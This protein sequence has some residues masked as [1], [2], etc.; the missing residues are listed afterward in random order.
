MISEEFLPIG[1][2]IKLHNLKSKVMIAGF[3]LK[4][5]DS[6]Y[7]YCGVLYPGGIKDKNSY[8]YFYKSDITQIVKIGPIDIESIVLLEKVKE[9]F[10]NSKK[11]TKG[12]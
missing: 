8:L 12:Y 7:D 6:I 5:N 9:F 4:N 3:C 11:E 1:S 2:I 10:R